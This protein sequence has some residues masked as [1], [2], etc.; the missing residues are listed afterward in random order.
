MGWLGADIDSF[1]W[2]DMPKAMEVL[3]ADPQVTERASSEMRRLRAEVEA[4]LRQR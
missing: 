2:A 4:T 3:G 1:A